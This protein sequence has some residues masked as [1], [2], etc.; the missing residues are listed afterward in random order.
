MLFFSIWGVVN[1]ISRLSQQFGLHDKSISKEFISLFLAC[2]FLEYSNYNTTNLNLNSSFF[3]FYGSMVSSINRLLLKFFKFKSAGGILVNL[4]S[5]NSSFSTYWR[6]NMLF[7]NFL[8][9]L[10]PKLTDKS[11]FNFT[12]SL[13]RMISF[14]RRYLILKSLNFDFIHYGLLSFLCYF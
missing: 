14:K 12:I 10:L 7:G 9:L 4:F 1:L 6:L 8:I 13:I 11:F 5:C 2:F 3:I